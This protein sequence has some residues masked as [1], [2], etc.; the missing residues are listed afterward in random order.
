[1]TYNMILFDIDP[2]TKFVDK[3][4]ISLISLRSPLFS[5]RIFAW[6]VCYRVSK[7]LLDSTWL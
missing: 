6:N 3:L 7:L 1:M 5:T 4:I 2:S